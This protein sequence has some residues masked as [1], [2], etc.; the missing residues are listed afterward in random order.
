MGTFATMKPVCPKFQN[1]CLTEKFH[2][3]RK[4]TKKPDYQKDCSY[5]YAISLQRT[6]SGEGKVQP[7]N[8]TTAARSRN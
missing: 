6:G 8:Y 1:S 5:Y 3:Q 2:D 4:R 7:Q